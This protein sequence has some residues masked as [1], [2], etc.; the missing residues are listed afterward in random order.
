M[1]HVSPNGL[2][3]GEQAIALAYM[4]GELH[5]EQYAQF[6]ARLAT[7]VAL[8]DELETLE[9]AAQIAQAR[10]AEQGAQA[11]FERFIAARQIQTSG[12]NKVPGL[13][14]DEIGRSP[15]NLLSAPKSFRSR[16]AQWMRDHATAL[17]PA[18]IALIVVQAAVIGHM[19][20]I[21]NGSRAIRGT[22]TSCNDVWITFRD[23]ASEAA[24]RSWLTFYDASIVDGPDMSGRYRIATRSDAGRAALLH[25]EDAGKLVRDAQAPQGCAVANP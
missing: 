14:N 13:Q 9:A 4:R 17:Q 12:G 10:S 16:I 25:S 5:K 11:A 20:S 21:D 1:S 8:R 6:A 3:D 18:F 24:L 23:G 19:A 15:S 2:D 22:P 7:D